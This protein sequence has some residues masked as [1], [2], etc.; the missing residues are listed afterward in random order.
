MSTEP[1]L[2][3]FS[4]LDEEGQRSLFSSISIPSLYAFY[5]YLAD[6]PTSVYILSLT[7]KKVLKAVLK[8]IDV[9]DCLRIIQLVV[10][11]KQAS[12]L[13]LIEESKWMEVLSIMDDTSCKVVIK[14][15]RLCKRRRI[16][17]WGSCCSIAPIIGKHSTN[18]IEVIMYNYKQV[19]LIIK[20]EG[21]LS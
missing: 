10:I 20:E 1:L 17:K 16:E 9:V 2:T 6:D 14:R 7:P 11:K 3:A 13:S 4:N 15:L 19:R 21:S 18:L 8:S 12:A 5:K